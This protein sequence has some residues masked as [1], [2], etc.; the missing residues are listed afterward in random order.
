MYWQVIDFWFEDLDPKQWFK[1]DDDF[2]RLLEERFGE[3]VHQA[4]AGELW[5]WRR[6]PQGRLAEI[7][8]LDQF[9]RN[10]FR[11]TPKAF[12]QDAQALTLAQEAVALNIDQELS[13]VQRSF[14]YMPYMHSE[15]PLVQEESVRLFEL[16]AIPSNLHFAKRHKEIIDQFG[17]YPHRNSILGRDSSEA[18]I[19]FLQTPGSSF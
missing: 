11:D 4:S 15:S 13:P 18:E 9:A 2:D 14:L 6:E 10:I 12:A 7:I 8:L 17:R 5:Q 1:K 19:A 3:L 16:L